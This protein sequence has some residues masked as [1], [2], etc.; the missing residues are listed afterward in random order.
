MPFSLHPDPAEGVAWVTIVHSFTI[1]TILAVPWG[2]LAPTSKAI[3]ER[4]GWEWLLWI[5]GV[6]SGIVV[7]L[8]IFLLMSPRA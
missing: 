6:W 5:I 3:D 8:A 4:I 7:A 2:V 1:T